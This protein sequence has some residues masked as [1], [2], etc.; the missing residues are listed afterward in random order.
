MVIEV[1]AD[2]VEWFCGPTHWRER[3][4]SCEARSLDAHQSVPAAE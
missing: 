4:F 2:A 3:Q 1:A